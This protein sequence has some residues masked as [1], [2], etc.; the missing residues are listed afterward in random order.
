MVDKFIVAALQ[1]EADPIIEFYNL[2][3]DTTHSDLKVYTN[4]QYNLLVTGVGKKVLDTLPTY[5]NRIYNVNS[6]LI[7]I[8]IAGGNPSCSKI[9]NIYFIDS[10]SSD[11]SNEEYVF[12][13]SDDIIIPK[14]GLRTV[15]NNISKNDNN[16]YKELVDMEAMVITDIAIKLF[17]LSKIKI[18]KIV[19]DHMDILDFSRLNIRQLIQSNLNTISYLIELDK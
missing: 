18:I 1:E 8:G 11:Y 9:G 10:L 15:E 17:D 3:R 16:I 4:N 19:S 7:N 12:P 13:I 6:I 2:S 5:L 14:V